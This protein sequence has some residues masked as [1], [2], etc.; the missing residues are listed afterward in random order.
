MNWR[1]SK[2]PPSL[3]ISS[4]SLNFLILSPF[5]RSPAAK[6]QQVVTAWLSHL[7]SLRACFWRLPFSAIKKVRIV[8][9]YLFKQK[10]EICLCLA[11]LP[12][13]MEKKNYPVFWDFPTLQWDT[14]R[15]RLAGA[16]MAQ[17]TLPHSDVQPPF[18]VNWVLCNA[19]QRNA[20]QRY[21]I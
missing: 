14:K 17:C 4:L 21:A 3:S 2:F 10:K 6:L 8:L 16:A 9:L 11:S 5:P 15:A 19:T 7:P 20:T 12:C 13:S 1:G 18:G